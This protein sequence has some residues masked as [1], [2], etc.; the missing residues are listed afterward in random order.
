MDGSKSGKSKDNNKKR[1]KNK[2]KTQCFLWM[3]ECCVVRGGL[4]GSS[5]VLF[6]MYL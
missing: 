3:T 1:K 4:T 5:Q 6:K 2:K